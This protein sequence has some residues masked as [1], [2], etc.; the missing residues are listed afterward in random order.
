ML[1]RAWKRIILFTVLGIV[2]IPAMADLP[3]GEAKFF[4]EASDRV[5][6]IGLAASLAGEFADH[7][8][9]FV[10]DE[11]GLIATAYH[12]VAEVLQAD[13][14]IGGKGRKASTPA[15]QQIY[16]VRKGARI[17][18][19]LWA[20]DSA[21]DLAVLKIPFQ[22]A[23]P[24]P[25]S[26]EKMKNGR[27]VSLMGYPGSSEFSIVSGPVQNSKISQVV[28][29][30]QITAPVTGGMSGGPIVNS[31]GEV[32]G[33]T[34]ARIPNGSDV[35]IAAQSESLRRFVE[36]YKKTALHSS[37]SPSKEELLN[38]I[39]EGDHALASQQ[40]AILRDYFQ[41][42]TDF[43]GWKIP[44]SADQFPDIRCA[45]TAMGQSDQDED[46]Q[47]VK[48]AERSCDFKMA[49]DGSRVS[50]KL[51]YAVMQS[52]PHPLQ[53]AGKS[54]ALLNS[55]RSRRPVRQNKKTFHCSKD[56]SAEIGRQAFTVSICARED[57]FTEDSFETVVRIASLAFHRPALV[58][59]LELNGFGRV[60]TNELV[61]SFIKGIGVENGTK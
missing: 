7:G 29:S 31:M 40:A 17:E 57:R 13:A 37:V 53:M 54:Q 8:T 27:R 15:K 56:F 52:G 30:Y 9:A 39:T 25:V 21:N 2:G 24:W 14:K 22:L 55:D 45:E 51:R 34:L 11:H 35:V 26:L 16:I 18:A 43:H 20:V 36:R 3:L 58:A 50:F 47:K 48:T 49:S 6:K 19:Q 10:V 61:A 44:S 42:G 46:L 5:F 4:D 12:V 28:S 23:K 41:N 32:I 59:E 33:V 60:L 1:F 38:Q